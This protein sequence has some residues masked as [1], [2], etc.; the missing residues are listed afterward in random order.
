M[1]NTV[2]TVL[3]VPQDEYILWSMVNT[4]ITVLFVP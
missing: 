1:V 4:V 3:F 2:I